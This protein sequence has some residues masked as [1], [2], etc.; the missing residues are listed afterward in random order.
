M[1]NGKMKTAGAFLAGGIIGAGVAILFAPHSGR[2]TRRELKHL[3][4]KALI[5]SEALGMDLRHSIDNLVDD[6][7]DKFKTGVARGKE[8][9]RRAS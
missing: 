2:R 1:L 3:G 8:W 4:K 6:L 9:S 5:R 7:S